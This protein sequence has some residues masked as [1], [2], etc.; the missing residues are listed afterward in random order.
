M[1]LP[2]LPVRVQPVAMKAVATK[3]IAGTDNGT[4]VLKKGTTSLGTIT[5]TASDAIGTA[6]SATPT[7][8]NFETTDKLRLSVAKTTAG[9]KAILFLTLEVLPSH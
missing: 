3:A 6:R 9:G 7:A 1:D 5:F 4:I 2:E 8:A